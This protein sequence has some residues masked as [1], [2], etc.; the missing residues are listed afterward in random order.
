MR[1]LA[2][3]NIANSIVELLRSFGHDVCDVKEQQWFGKSDAFLVLLAKKEKRIIV[4][5]DKDFIYQEKVA[6]LLLRFQN[7]KPNHTKQYLS[8]FFKLP[9]S[10]K[11]EKVITALLSEDGAVFS[12]PQ[13]L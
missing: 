6:V 5:H 8:A 2:D 13:G 1:F 10:R 3:E 11:L 9:E 7:Q 12:P 4:T